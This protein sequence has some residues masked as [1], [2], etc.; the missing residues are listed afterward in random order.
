[1][2]FLTWLLSCN[3]ISVKCEN[4]II[5][6]NI[7]DNFDDSYILLYNKEKVQYIGRTDSGYDYYLLEFNKKKFYIKRNQNGFGICTNTK[8]LDLDE[9]QIGTINKLP[10]LNKINK[11]LSLLDSPN[12]KIYVLSDGLKIVHLHSNYNGNCNESNNDINVHNSEYILIYNNF[13]T[14]LSYN[15]LNGCALFSKKINI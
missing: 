15:I 14:I 4:C 9:L 11:T 10:N 1:M 2:N 3:C 12:I 7:L 8:E 13:Y 5:E 6:L